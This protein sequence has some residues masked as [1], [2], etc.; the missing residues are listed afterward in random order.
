MSTT[1]RFRLERV[2]ALRERRED[3]AR[4]ELAKAVTRL[5][6]S[7]ERLQAVEEHL[8]RVHAEQR[9]AS[10]PAS[11]VDIQELRAR[12]AIV[13]QVEAQRAGGTHE[14]AQREADVAERDGELG[15]AARE[16]RML[17]RLKERQHAE[18]DR[19]TRRQESIVLDEIA[20]DGFRRSAA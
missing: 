1:F 16:H 8:E 12:Q 19:E 2:R 9:L 11:A 5:A 7:R 3:L 10:R 13:E 17:E 20:I 4:Q 14:L 6:G 15:L 18:H